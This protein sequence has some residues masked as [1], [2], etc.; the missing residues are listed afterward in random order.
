MN[1][2]GA[3]P[4]STRPEESGV[5]TS[6]RATL[7][8]RPS[9]APSARA[10][11]SLNDFAQILDPHTQP[12]AQ[13]DQCPGADPN[14]LVSVFPDARP[15]QATSQQSLFESGTISELTL[16]CTLFFDAPELDDGAGQCA[17]IEHRDVLFTSAAKTTVKADPLPVMVTAM[18]TVVG[19]MVQRPGVRLLIEVSAACEGRGD[20]TRVSD[21]LKK[22][23][24]LNRDEFFAASPY[25][26]P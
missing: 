6:K 15:K 9:P 21:K 12:T 23:F 1:S 10:N 3:P 19:G 22:V 26:R 13:A 8:S 16:K 20:V 24:T 4:A 7:P 2:S 25:A 11:L 18:R 5:P 17:L 14:R